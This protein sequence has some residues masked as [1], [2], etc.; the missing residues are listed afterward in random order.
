MRKTTIWVQTKSDTNQHVQ[1]QK[2]AKSLIFGIEEEEGLYY[3]C[4][5]NKGADQLRG[6]SK[7]DLR[8]CFRLCRLLSF[9]AAAHMII[10]SMLGIYAWLFMLS[11]DFSQNV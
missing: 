4:S 8:L 2:Q 7:A 5:E 6:Y 3:S 10:F 1:S 11:T 9:H